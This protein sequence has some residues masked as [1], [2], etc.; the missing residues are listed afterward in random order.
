M[1]LLLACKAQANRA[2]ISRVQRTTLTPLAM[3]LENAERFAEAAAALEAAAAAAAAAEG[4]EGGNASRRASLAPSPVA[5]QQQQ[6][7]R[8]PS[9]GAEQ[10]Q[11]QSPVPTLPGDGVPASSDSSS[12]DR[13][14]A[15]DAATAAGRP[16]S[17]VAALEHVQQQGST[18][19][20]LSP[21]GGGSSSSRRTTPA[22][23]AAQEAADD[24]AA[25]DELSMLQAEVAFLGLMSNSSS[26]RQSQQQSQD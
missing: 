2:L 15:V 17:R 9:R 16:G 23:A 20:S 3:Q 12:P 22:A 6:H 26:F 14:A 18:A 1:L 25:D 11:Q 13:F 8:T 4:R 5:Q 19:M 24:A 21:G 10:R 7:S